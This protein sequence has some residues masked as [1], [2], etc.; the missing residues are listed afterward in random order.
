M[1]I[2]IIPDHWNYIFLSNFLDCWLYVLMN[3]HFE[4][5]I[6]IFLQILAEKKIPVFFFFWFT[7]L[8]KKNVSGL[9]LPDQIPWFPNSFIHSF[10]KFSLNAL[11]AFKALG[12]QWL[13]KFH[14]IPHGIYGLMEDIGKCPVIGDECMSSQW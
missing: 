4:K 9:H 13:I 2:R 8:V 5:N 11:S 1:T 6:K 7:V 14:T 10:H 3:R 12:I